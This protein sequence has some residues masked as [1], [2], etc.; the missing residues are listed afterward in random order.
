MIRRNGSFQSEIRERMRGGEGSA[1]IEHIWKAKEDLG[2]QATRLF[3]KVTL[4]PG[5]G[6]GTHPHDKEE[7]IYVILS[8]E[9]EVEDNGVK[10]I[11][12]PGDSILTGNGATHSIKCHGDKKLEFLAVINTF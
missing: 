4:E 7:E 5:C 10:S 9:A 6:I 3:A 2:A 1:K 8:G 12:K 11:L